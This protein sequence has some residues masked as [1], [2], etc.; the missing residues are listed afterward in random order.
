MLAVVTGALLTNTSAAPAT[1]V[2]PTVTSF[3]FTSEAGDY[4]VT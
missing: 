3:A 2:E 4:W 1:A